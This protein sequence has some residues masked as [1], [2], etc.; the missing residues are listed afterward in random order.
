MQ[1]IS[2]QDYTKEIIY[3]MVSINEFK[4][5]NNEDNSFVLI[6]RRD[7]RRLGKKL[8]TRGLDLEGCSANCAITEHIIIR[9]TLESKIWVSSYF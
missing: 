5:P 7:C 9:H 4:Y 2:H 3:G 8:M 1:D 6:S